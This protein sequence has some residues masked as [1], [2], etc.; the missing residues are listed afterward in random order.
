ME[1]FRMQIDK[2]SRMQKRVETTDEASL[3]TEV[4]LPVGN[5]AIVK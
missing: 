4:P 1:I 3:H 2:E 5:W